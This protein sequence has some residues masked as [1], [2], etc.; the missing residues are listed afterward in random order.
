MVERESFG[1]KGRPSI[2]Y[3]AIAKRIGL[4]QPTAHPEITDLLARIVDQSATVASQAYKLALQKPA[5]LR[6]GVFRNHAFFSVVSAPSK[7]RLRRIN[8]L[9]E[10]LAELAWTPDDTPG[11]K[12]RFTWLVSPIDSGGG[13]KSK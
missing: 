10:E 6:D 3:R 9:L 11:Q 1:P 7:A 4:G 2:V 8:K 12:M 5:D 13:K